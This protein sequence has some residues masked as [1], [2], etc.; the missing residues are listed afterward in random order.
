VLLIRGRSLLVQIRSQ[1]TRIPLATAAGSPLSLWL[2]LASDSGD[3]RHNARRGGGHGFQ[4]EGG[5]VVDLALLVVVRAL[6]A[7]GDTLRH[8]GWPVLGVDLVDSV[9]I[10][11]V[12]T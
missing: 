12:R 11:L 10:E 1:L 7:V 8:V 5:G 6:A 2:L 4:I 9:Q 3:L